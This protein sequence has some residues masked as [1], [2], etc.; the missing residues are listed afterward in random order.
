MYIVGSMLF[1]DSGAHEPIFKGPVK[2]FRFAGL[3]WEYCLSGLFDMGM[4]GL[5]F[6]PSAL[7]KHGRIMITIK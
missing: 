3:P 6:R 5:T 4:S 2:R 1:H 7:K